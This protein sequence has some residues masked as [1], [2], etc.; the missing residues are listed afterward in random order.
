M[1]YDSDLLRRI[2]LKYDFVK[3][4]LADHIITENGCWEYQGYLREGGYGYFSIDCAELHPKKRKFRA[5]RVAYAFFSGVDPGEKFVCHAC[6]NPRCIN[7][8]HLFLGTPMDNTRDMMEKGRNADQ[9]GGS[10][11]NAKLTEDKVRIII[12]RIMDGEQNMVIADDFGVTHHVISN[13]R[14]GKAWV[15]VANDMDYEAVKKRG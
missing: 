14:R 8:G 2:E 15:G 13:I 9:A 6:D 4:K 3:T 12:K 5:H 1:K 11:N 10:N 7:P